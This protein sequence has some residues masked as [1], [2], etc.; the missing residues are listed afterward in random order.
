MYLISEGN[1]K[2]NLINFQVKVKLIPSK[3]NEP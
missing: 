3:M 2:P 1:L